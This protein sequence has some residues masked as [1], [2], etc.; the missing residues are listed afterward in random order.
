MKNNLIK[1]GAI[2][3]LSAIGLISLPIIRSYDKSSAADAV[4]EYTL[5]GDINSDDVVDVFDIVTL[6]KKIADKKQIN[7]VI[8]ILMG[9]L[10]KKI[11]C[12]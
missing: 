5:F 12:F 1:T 8:L 3:S 2:V 9:R 6:R 11:F 4:K 10:M 7:N